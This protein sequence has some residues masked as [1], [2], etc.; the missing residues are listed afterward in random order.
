MPRQVG[1][2]V[3]EGLA[4]GNRCAEVAEAVG[5]RRLDLAQ[6]NGAPPSE[7]G[8]GERAHRDCGDD[9]DQHRAGD[10]R[11]DHQRDAP[12]R[13][14]AHQELL[15]T[16]RDPGLRQPQLRRAGTG[17]PTRPAPGGDRHADEQ[18]DEQGAERSDADRGDAIAYDLV[19]RRNLPLEWLQRID[20]S[21]DGL[22]S[23]SDALAINAVGTFVTRRAAIKSGESTKSTS[24]LFGKPCHSF[25]A[26][27]S[28]LMCS[29]RVDP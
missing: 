9:R 17:P 19:D 1:E 29:S 16:Q 6:A 10:D 22:A 27:T 11:A 7:V 15:W 20:D 24:G 2:C 3:R 5:P 12:D 18:P 25:C 26:M 21:D 4:G 23:A 28:T 13:E 8:T 14:R